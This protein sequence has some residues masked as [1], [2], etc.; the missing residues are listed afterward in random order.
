MRWL[1]GMAPLGAQTFGNDISWC[2]DSGMTVKWFARPANPSSHTQEMRLPG[3]GIVRVNIDKHIDNAL[4][5][6]A[7]EHAGRRKNP[8]K[9]DRKP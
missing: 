5:S 2:G 1:A 8:A 6:Q 9:S 3:V 4:K 7:N